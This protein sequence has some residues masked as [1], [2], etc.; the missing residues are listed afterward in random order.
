GDGKQLRIFI[1][2]SAEA[3][4]GIVPMYID[5]IG[6]GPFRIRITR[7]VGAKIPPKVFN[8]PIHPEFA[9]QI[10]KCVL[11]Q[12][13]ETDSCDVL[14]FGPV[15]EL[16]PP[17]AA[18]QTAC[19]SLPDLVASCE[20]TTGVHSVFLLPRSTE[21]YY[22]S[23]SKNE[24]KNRRKYDLRMMRKDYEVTVDIR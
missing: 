22:A 20:N 8:P 1:F 4:V 5:T 13:L 11:E 18:L 10:F 23:L 15:S 19:A 9:P 14:S 3:I 17:A 16:H 6:A 24:R 12:L 7:L 21:E 2:R